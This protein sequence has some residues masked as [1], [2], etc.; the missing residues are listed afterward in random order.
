VRFSLL[1][2]VSTGSAPNPGSSPPL[3]LNASRVADPFAEQLIAAADARDCARELV[4]R[5]IKTPFAQP[6]P[7]RQ[8]VLCARKDDSSGVRHFIG[9]GDVAHNNARLAR[10]RIKIV[11]IGNGWQ[12]NDCNRQ[13]NVRGFAAALQRNSIFLCHTQVF[14]PRNH[15]KHRQP[16]ALFEDAHTIGKQRRITTKTVDDQ[17]P[18]QGAF[19]RFEQHQ[20]AEQLGENTAGV[21]VANE[22]DTCLRVGCHPHVHNVARLE[23]QF[24]RTARSF[25]DDQVVAGA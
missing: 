6:A 15:T 20:G 7:R 12:M 11:E 5:R 13:S 9:T 8:R 23:V 14:D 17:S 2:T 22:R 16:A 24:H 4:Q 10:Q 21:D 18:H 19:L 25:G 1:K 3:P